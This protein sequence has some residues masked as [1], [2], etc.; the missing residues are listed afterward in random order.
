MISGGHTVALKSSGWPD[1]AIVVGTQMSL[2]LTELDLF[3][4][5][6]SLG[7]NLE[8]KMLYSDI[9]PIKRGSILN[10]ILYHYIAFIRTSSNL[11]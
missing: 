2:N 7:L 1:G 11:S 8:I 4:Q 5:T 9:N 10:P 6:K 3:M